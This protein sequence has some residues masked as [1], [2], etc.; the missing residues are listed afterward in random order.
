M[1][2]GCHIFSTSIYV[3]GIYVYGK[4]YKYIYGYKLCK[5]NCKVPLFNLLF[6]L[7]VTQSFNF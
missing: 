5:A 2:F 6:F 3:Y 4:Y 1:K 7:L